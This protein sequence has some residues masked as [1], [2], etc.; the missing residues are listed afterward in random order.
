MSATRSISPWWFLLLLPAAPAAGWMV[1]AMPVPKLAP[2]PPAE[3][4]AVT[5]ARPE[6]P[7]AG[8]IQVET[9]DANASRPS[10]PPARPEPPKAELSSWTSYDNALAESRRNGKP[11]LID[12]NAAW[13][14][15]CQAL[16]REVFENGQLGHE[17]QT[18]VIP[19][20]IVDRQREDGSNPSDIEELQQRYG[21]DAFPTLVI[22]S[23]AT[24]RV[25]KTRG[26]GDPERTLTWITSAANSVR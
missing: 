19:V 25:E 26:Y 18:A 23:P 4:H 7:P 8:S 17:V 12:F 14:G 3:T 24:G 20:S 1:G 15:P 6:G 22:F 16:R 13:C 11:I 5:A 21:V 10:P 2:P 9:A